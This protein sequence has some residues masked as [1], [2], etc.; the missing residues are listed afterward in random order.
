MTSLRYLIL[1]FLLI[2]LPACSANVTPQQKHF[3]PEVSAAAL[4]NQIYCE[5]KEVQCDAG[6]QRTEW[7]TEID[8]PPQKVWA[9]LT[10]YE[11]YPNLIPSATS[12]KIVERNGN[13]LVIDTRGRRVIKLQG[14]VRY[15]EDP[16]HFILKWEKIKS[17]LNLNSGY[18]ELTPID[19]DGRT[20]TQVYH[21][22][23]SAPNIIERAGNMTSHLEQ[24]EIVMITKIR[25]IAK[26]Q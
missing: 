17:N 6:S 2:A 9:A 16:E 23:Y 18:W 19:R 12:Y 3:A 24:D 8:A 22:V 15:T 7:R 20:I 11:N 13:T 25:E 4:D 10:N 1:S 21:Y 26:K 14:R 5:T